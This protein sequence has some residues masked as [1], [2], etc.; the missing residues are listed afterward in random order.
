MILLL[1]EDHYIMDMIT[2]VGLRSSECNQQWLFEASVE[3]GGI[4]EIVSPFSKQDGRR[5]FAT[6]F[7]RFIQGCSLIRILLAYII[8][9][10]IV[11]CEWINVHFPKGLVCFMPY[12]YLPLDQNSNSWINCPS[13]SED[14]LSKSPASAKNRFCFLFLQLNVWASLCWERGVCRVWH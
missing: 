13:Q 4:A 5:R 10:S 8:V 6:C 2:F 14:F 11:I 7:F 1:L 3:G 12:R 9:V